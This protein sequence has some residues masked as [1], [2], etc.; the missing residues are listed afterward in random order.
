MPDKES[1]KWCGN[2]IEVL[3]KRTEEVK[4]L[5]VYVLKPENIGEKMSIDDKAIGRDGFTILSNSDSGK[6][7][8]MIESVDAQP[9]ISALQLF[10]NELDNI[11]SISMD[12]SPTY[13]LVANEL[14]PRATQVADK[15]HVMKYV[16]DAVMSVRLRLRKSLSEQLSE[17]KN[18]NENDKIILGKIELLKR[19]THAITQSPDKWSLEMQ[20]TVNQVFKEFSELE[21]AYFLSQKLKKWYT[22]ENQIGRTKEQQIADLHNWYF[23]VKNSKINEF[24]GV[25]KMMRKHETVILNYFK[26][27]QTNAKAER[28]NGKIQRFVTNNYGVKEKDFFLYRIANYFS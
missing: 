9:V 19:V 2:K 25:I 18:R 1:G 21:T 24:N 4:K 28:L 16:Y 15:F 14:L 8:M 3:D 23:D 11:K 22:F 12:M 13:A 5:P 17:G 20:Q 27:G 26:H 10:G 6:I 7:A